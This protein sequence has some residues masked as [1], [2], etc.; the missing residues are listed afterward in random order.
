MNDQSN[1]RLGF[2]KQANPEAVAILK[3]ALLEQV[4]RGVD[5]FLLLRED[6]GSP[7]E[8]QFLAA[9][10]AVSMGHG[11]AIVFREGHI[12]HGPMP[13]DAPCCYL[14]QPLGKYRADFFLL[15]KTDAGG[16]LR[17]AVECDGHDYHE[18]TKAQ[19]A[20]DRKRDREMLAQGIHVM[21]FTGS[22][23]YADADKCAWDV[24]RFVCILGGV[25]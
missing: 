15:T 6:C 21:R 14:Q 2:P 13:D 3:K 23:I 19:A 1:I 24:F 4:E 18:R 7:I 12:E 10:M 11:D 8:E 25:Q 20:R 9:L 17:V 16:W 5:T 22:E